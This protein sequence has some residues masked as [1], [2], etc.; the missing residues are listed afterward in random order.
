MTI[1]VSKIPHDVIS[2]VATSNIVLHVISR[3]NAISSNLQKLNSANL[4]F[5][6]FFCNIDLLSDKTEEK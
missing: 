3:N 2:A 5:T 4:L 6:H 1:P